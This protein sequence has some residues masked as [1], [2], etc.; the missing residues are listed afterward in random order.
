[1]SCIQVGCMHASKVRRHNITT[2]CNLCIIAHTV[3]QRPTHG[4]RT[5][6]KKGICRLLTLTVHQNDNTFKL[7]HQT[8]PARHAGRCSRRRMNAGPRFFI[9][10]RWYHVHQM[11]TVHCQLCITMAHGV[12]QHDKQ[13]TVYLRYATCNAVM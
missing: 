5:D 10:Q 2:S 9:A 11:Y 1:M 4:E 13:H 12:R 7:S 8:Q 3:I 6:S